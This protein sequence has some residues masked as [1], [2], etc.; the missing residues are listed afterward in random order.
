MRDPRRHERRASTTCIIPPEK[1]E[2]IK[3]TKVKVD[4]IAEHYE[5]GVITDGERYN[6]VIDIWTHT[7]NRGRAR[8]VTTTLSQDRDGFNPIYMMA[9]SG[10]RGSR[11]QIRQLAGMRG[12]MAKPQKKITGGSA[13]SSRTRSSPTS[14]KA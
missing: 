14:R 10:A 11:E 7:T 2:I 6:Q 13:R 5:N 3:G 8:H 1:D 9:D 12:L 4:K